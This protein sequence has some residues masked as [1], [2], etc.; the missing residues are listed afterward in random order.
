MNKANLEALRGRAL[1]FK[2][3]SAAHRRF[4]CFGG[5]LAV[6]MFAAAIALRLT[7][8]GSFP[9]VVIFVAGVVTML[10]CGMAYMDAHNAW[11]RFVSAAGMYRAAARE[12]SEERTR[13]AA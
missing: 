6:V 13:V 11:Q 12:F 7:M 10:R 1:Y 3:L 5:L 4:A 9:A 2:N 8:G